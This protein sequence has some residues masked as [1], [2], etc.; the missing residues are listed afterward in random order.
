MTWLSHAWPQVL[1]LTRAHLLLSVQAIAL[2]LLLAV[3][4]G[5]AAA[6]FPRVG[7]ALTSAATLLYAVPALPLLIIVPAVLGVPLR[8]TT[9]VVAALTVYGVALMVRS[10][11]DAFTAVDPSVRQAAQA[12]GHSRWS[13][14]WR[15][16][17]PLAVPL[18][19]A[20]ARVVCVSTVGLVT[21]GALIG[22]PSLGTLFT[23]GF[24][25]GIVAEVAT[26]VLG[27]VVI[28]LALDGLCA[29]TGRAL[30][31]WARTAPEPHRPHAP[32]RAGQEVTT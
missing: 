8:S 6:R 1:D 3:P 17:L 23:D 32:V 13:L 14:G 15:V 7:G 10:A 26:G 12:V 11:T 5:Y 22:V 19:V 27:T 18:L 9:T 25:R 31:P 2:S 24:Q 20:G 4:A 29:L 28:G 30:T 16:D 21:I